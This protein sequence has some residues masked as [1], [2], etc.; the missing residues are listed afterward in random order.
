MSAE[1]PRLSE[2]LAGPRDPDRCQACGAAWQDLGIWQEHDQADRPEP[3]FVV[4]CMPCSRRLIDPHPRLYAQ[5]DPNAPAPGVMALCHDCR[6]RDGTRC[7]CPLAAANGG[8]GIGIKAHGQR[9]HFLCRPRRLSGNRT[10]WTRPPS[11]CSGKDPSIR[12]RPEDDS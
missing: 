6:H 8:P 7:A 2:S 4:L 9:A 5:L 11:A 3:V 10:L 12:L 1:W